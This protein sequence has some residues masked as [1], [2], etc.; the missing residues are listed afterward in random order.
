MSPE[1]S[2]TTAREWR[3]RSQEI[4]D[5]VNERLR[6]FSEAAETINLTL[7]ELMQQDPTQAGQYG[8]EV[9]RQ[10][11]SEW[12]YHGDIF[13]VTGT[14]HE[15]TLAAS[16]NHISV[17]HE[18]EQVFIATNSNGF[19][20]KLVE[21]PIDSDIWVPRIGLSFNYGKMTMS[22]PFYQTVTEPLAFAEP[23]EIS[24]HYLRPGSDEVV[25]ADL[26]DIGHAINQSASLLHLITTHPNSEYHNASPKRQ[27]QMIQRLVATVE[28][29]LPT[30]ESFDKLFIS[31]DTRILQLIDTSRSSSPLNLIPK[32][33]SLIHVEGD[34]VGVTDTT[35]VVDGVE[36][37][38]IGLIVT[39][40]PNGSN[41]TPESYGSG[42][43]I[44][45]IVEAESLNLELR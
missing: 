11:D 8:S 39:P 31:S 26:Q 41:F 5:D 1:Y 43:Y 24:M 40:E 35:T 9:I 16:G 29:T 3:A 28:E 17:T 33:N 27:Q 18:K 37:K 6:E 15:P 30:P 21:S 2:R 36:T 19:T 22:T 44:I 23:H 10:L 4:N 42:S 25:G 14:W 13:F 12:P 32:Q 45:P 34:V 38:S 7:A 20:V